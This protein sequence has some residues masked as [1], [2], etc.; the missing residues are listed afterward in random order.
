MKV[1]LARAQIKAL[2]IR[3]ILLYVYTMRTDGPTADL[4]VYVTY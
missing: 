3:N 2:D 1:L 4:T